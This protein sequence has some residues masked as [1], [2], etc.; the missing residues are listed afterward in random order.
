M[1]VGAVGAGLVVSSLGFAPAF[2]LTA[3]AMLPA[4]L[5]AGRERGARGPAPA[6]LD[7]STGT[8]LDLCPEPARS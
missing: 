1:A 6:E 5:L 3:A 8:E 4:L 7:H 2:L